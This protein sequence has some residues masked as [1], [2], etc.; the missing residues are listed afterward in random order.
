MALEIMEAE[1]DMD[2]I[3]VPIGGGGMI[4]GVVAAVRGKY[5]KVKI[6]VSGF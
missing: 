2:Y 5:P 4:A 3:V 6:I 1:P